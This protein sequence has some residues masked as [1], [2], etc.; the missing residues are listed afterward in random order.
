M[1]S[2]KFRYGHEDWCAPHI[3][4]N[5]PFNECVTSDFPEVLVRISSRD[6]GGV[7]FPQHPPILG[8]HFKNPVEGESDAPRRTN[9]KK[10]T[11]KITCRGPGSKYLSWFVLVW[12]MILTH[13]SGI[14][15]PSALP[16]G[17]ACD[18]MDYFWR[19]RVEGWIDSMHPISAYP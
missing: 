1:D 4:T 5:L 10:Q 8:P 14:S 9:K 7:D 18:N 19:R 2:L 16:V 3:P 15:L 13:V 12:D 11:N 6:R 17:I